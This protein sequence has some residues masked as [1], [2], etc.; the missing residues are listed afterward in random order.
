MNSLV[1]SLKPAL[2]SVLKPVL[3]PVVY[4]ALDALIRLGGHRVITPERQIFNISPEMGRGDYMALLRGRYE[5]AELSILRRSFRNA[6]TI[7]ELGSNIGIVA[8]HALTQRMMPGGQMICVEPNETSLQALRANTARALKGVDA[9][10]SF[11]HAAVGAADH[12]DVMAN[13]L[14][15]PNLSSGLVTQVAPQPGDKAPVSVR[16]TSLSDILRLHAVGEY[17]LICDIEGGEIPLLYEDGAS[18]AG[19]SQM[20]IEL[21]APELTGRDVRPRDMLR[22]LK[23]LGFA[24][25]DRVANTYYLERRLGV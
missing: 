5:A 22:Q 18:L 13:F 20:L 6:S 25:E 1:A 3:K 14:A 8:Y 11:V 4:G 9:R 12:G 15:R 7:V 2:K 21:H 16:V 24:C 23:R 17:S 10:V 19:C